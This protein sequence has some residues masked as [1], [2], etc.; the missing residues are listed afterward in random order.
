MFYAP[1]KLYVRIEPTP[2]YDDLGRRIP[3]TGH[4]CWQEAGECRHD[5]QTPSTNIL[6]SDNG[7]VWEKRHHIVCEG[8]ISLQGGD[9]IRCTDKS[10]GQVICEGEIQ[11][12]VPRNYFNVTDIWL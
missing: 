6:S 5:F 8:R 3:P 2:E 9:Y 11:P 12:P 10:T 1:H 7:Q 4:Y